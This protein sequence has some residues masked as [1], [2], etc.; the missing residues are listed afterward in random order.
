MA[1]DKAVDSGALNGLFTDIADA[2]RGKAGT[3]TT[4]TPTEMATAITELPAGLDA[5]VLALIKGNASGDIVATLPDNPRAMTIT[6]GNEAN[7]N[8][9]VTG[10]DLTFRDSWGYYSSGGLKFES[11]V[12]RLK[13]L[14]FRSP[15]GGEMTLTRYDNASQTLRKIDNLERVEF[16]KINYINTYLPFKGAPKLATA[17]LDY[18]QSVGEQWFQNCPLLHTVDLG[19][20]RT[21]KG[22]IYDNAF[23]DCSALT[24]LIIRSSSVWTISNTN[25]LSGTPIASGSGY[26]YV[27]ATRVDTYKA[28]T[29]W[30]TYASQFRALEDY[31]VDG[32]T[33]GALDPT[34]I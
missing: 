10:L 16:R 2:I 6:M 18:V 29:N 28:A 15:T 34:K 27:P 32:T 23:N 12:P 8:P 7:R 25:A 3:S 1:I 33:S 22:S 14:I 24:A 4:Y 30:T 20:L 21:T 31:T 13:T 17:L 9:N 5:G 26:I 11:N 19:G